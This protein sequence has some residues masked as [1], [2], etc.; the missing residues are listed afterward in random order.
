M[1]NWPGRLD[2]VEG[3]G[4]DFNPK[5]AV[6]Y[7]PIEQLVL[8]GNWS[9]S[10]RAPSLAQVG[11]GV[12]L[13]SFTV[14]CELTPGACADTNNNGDTSDEDGEPLLSEE[15]GNADLLA[16]EAESY[17]FGAVF[18]PTSDLTFSIDYWHIRHEDLV[19]VDEDDF[20]RRALAGEFPVVGEGALPTGSPGLEVRN[21]FVVD[22]HIPLQN[23]GFQETSGIDLSAT[24]LFRSR[25]SGVS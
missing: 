4:S 14:D 3:F 18:E 6:R 20:I 9:T 2:D 5:V 19:G 8:R 21:G 15:L 12:R 22:A 23:L 25:R 1:F 13:T 7:E 16:E 11:A 24:N 10:F 17:S